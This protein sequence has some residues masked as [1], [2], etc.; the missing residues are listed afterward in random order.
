LKQS[1][2]VRERECLERF[3]AGES[4]KRIAI[5]FNISPRTVQTHIASSYRKLGVSD[6]EGAAHAL[7]DYVGE[8]LRMDGEVANLLNQKGSG[9]IA[10]STEGASAAAFM[11]MARLP[12]PPRPPG[13][14]LTVVVLL[15]F[16]LTICVGGIVAALWVIFGALDSL[17]HLHGRATQ[18]SPLSPHMTML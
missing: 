4:A 5:A 1:L 10:G 14:R 13:G 15:A 12:L 17:R 3:V 18:E 7:R 16:G 11:D 2:T 6:R 8:P 9:S